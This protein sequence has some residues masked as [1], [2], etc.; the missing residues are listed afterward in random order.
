MERAYPA[1]HAPPIPNAFIW[2]RAHSLTGLWLVLFLIEHLFIN[3]QAALWI[4]DEGAGFVRAV[5]A[6]R[7]LPYLHVI[8]IF[9]LGVPF[10][11]HGV[12]GVQ[13]L[14]TAKLIL[15]RRMERPLPCRTIPE[16]MPLRGRGSP[17]G[18]YCLALSPM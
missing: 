5:N 15:F 9:L 14:M 12:W 18:F 11:I 2:R 7:D 13:Y 17:L 3:S 1:Y 16:I 6:L 4:G 8:E 10:V